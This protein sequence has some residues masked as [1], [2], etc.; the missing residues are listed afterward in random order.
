MS[1]GTSHWHDEVYFGIHYDLHAEAD[2]TA[3]GTELTRENL[4]DVLRR[5]R[6]DWVQC[7]CKG[8][9]GWTS[10]PTRTGSTS[11]GVVEDSL[12]VHADVCRELG[13][14]LGMHYSGVIDCRALEL[15]PKWAQID[16]DGKPSDRSTCRL[17]DYD[18]Q[19]MIPQL[20]EIIDAYDVD[21]FWV[22][23]ENWAVRPCWCPRCLAEFTRRTGLADAPRGADEPNWAAWLA[24]HRDVFV[25]HVTRC[26][27][28]V[29]ARKADCALCSNWMYTIRQPEP[30]AA[31]VDY[32]SG[33]YMPDFGAYRAALEGRFLD[34]RGA[35]W[36]LMCW[37]FT[38]HGDREGCVW[39]PASHLCQEVAEVVALGGAVMVY[40]KPQRTGR[41]V[42]WHHDI[43]AEVAEFCRERKEWCFRTRTASDAA[44]LHLA[45]HYYTCNEPSY[46][47]GRAV[48]PVEGALHALL[49]THRSTDILPEDAAVERMGDYGLI[50]VPEQTHLGDGL[51]AA[52]ERYAAAG[53]HVILSGAHLARDVPRL[54]GAEPA[55][56]IEFSGKHSRPWGDIFLACDGEAFALHGPCAAVRCTDAEPLATALASYDGETDR[57]EHV[58]VTRRAVGD[59]AVLAI[60]GPVFRDYFGDHDPRLRR[61]FGGLV[62]GLPIAWRVE[63]DA[64]AWLE[65]VA[66]R[67][68]GRLLI[69][70]VNRGSGE[71]TYPRRVIVDELP[72]VRDVTLRVRCE[73]RPAR[74]TLQPG[75]TAL[76][77]TREEDEGIATVRVPSVD[78]H[79]V[80]VME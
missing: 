75:G 3:L 79:R 2:D 53:G 35:S 18:E 5:V 6:P 4:R 66:R 73:A 16:A 47:Y 62:S 20:L 49:E 1:H 12:R 25:E 64:P 51:V 65:V 33:D 77:W 44:V 57:T 43:L 46:N 54:V 74:V 68:D 58:V 8:H 15:H 76:E 31:P 61:W 27:D 50:V 59:G 36:D 67:K 71:M 56:E 24:F 14:R 48:E 9:P 39:K 22:D 78:I 21:G 32:F 19:L 70:L 11:P 30:V 29:H 17:G 80:V 40:A 42:P 28:A 45:G 37:G 38:K 52:L 72:P 13:I 55:G 23:G 26:A 63:L 10:W 7:D 69:N 41:L 60:H 34:A